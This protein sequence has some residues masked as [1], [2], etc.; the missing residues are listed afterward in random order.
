MQTD[1]RTLSQNII[2]KIVIKEMLSI[3]DSN[4]ELVTSTKNIA[5][6]VQYINRSSSYSI[7]KQ[8]QRVSKS[9]S[10]NSLMFASDF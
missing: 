4:S 3:A 2:K 9:K 5:G 8:R 1:L 10:L 7:V 6:R